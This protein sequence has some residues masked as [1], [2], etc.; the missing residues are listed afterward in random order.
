LVGQV[1]DSSS[2]KPG[3]GGLQVILVGHNIGGGC[4]S[5]VMECFPNRIAKAI[6]VAA[7]M[8]CTGQRAFDV[9]AKQEKGEEDLMPKA[10]KFIYGNG[11]ASPPTAVELD[12]SLVRDLFFNASPAKVF[13]VLSMT[14]LPANLLKSW[15]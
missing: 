14:V 13:Q 2:N 8:V 12:K 6:F 11:N 1:K 9:F 5:Y 15:V 7:S 3:D 4:I 10:Q